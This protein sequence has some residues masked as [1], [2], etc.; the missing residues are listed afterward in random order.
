MRCARPR[1]PDRHLS[2][3]SAHERASRQRLA[4]AGAGADVALGLRDVAADGGLAKEIE[5]LGRRALPLQMDVLDL[6]QARGAIDAAVAG[7]GRLDILVNNAGGG[8]DG[9]ALEVGE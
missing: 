6:D 2:R 5:A 3:A 4:L 9:M 8:I 1:R 7:L